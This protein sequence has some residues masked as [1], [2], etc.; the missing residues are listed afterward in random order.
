MMHLV[1]VVYLSEPKDTQ[2][3]QWPDRASQPTGD[4]T[5]RKH[6]SGHT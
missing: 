5:F 4:R 6:G 1:P 2:S 3:T